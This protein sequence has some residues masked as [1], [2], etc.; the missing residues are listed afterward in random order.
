MF[1]KTT[2]LKG[3]AVAAAALSS[4]GI[5]ANNLYTDYSNVTLYS[6]VAKTYFSFRNMNLDEALLPEEPGHGKVRFPKW[7]KAHY[8]Q[9]GDMS[10]VSEINLR[11]RL[12]DDKDRN[13][14]IS[15]NDYVLISDPNSDAYLTSK[16]WGYYGHD[17]KI[18]HQLESDPQTKTPYKV[19]GLDKECIG[20]WPNAKFKLESTINREK[21]YKT[22]CLK[23]D[24]YYCWEWKYET[25]IA[26]GETLTDGQG[27]TE[28]LFSIIGN[29]NNNQE[30]LDTIQSHANNEAVAILSHRS[31]FMSGDAG[32]YLPTINVANDKWEILGAYP[33]TVL[34]HYCIPDGTMVKLK[35][36]GNKLFLAQDG[37]SFNMQQQGTDFIIENQQYPGG[38]IE[39]TDAFSLKLPNGNYVQISKNHHKM[40]H[41][42]DFHYKSM[43]FAYARNP[44]LDF[45]LNK[46]NLT[47]EVRDS[48]ANHKVPAHDGDLIDPSGSVNEV[49]P[50]DE[51][52]LK[53]HPIGVAMQYSFHSKK[54][55]F[56][57][58]TAFFIKKTG[59]TTEAQ[60][61]GTQGDGM[62]GWG[63]PL[64]NNRPHVLAWESF[65]FD[66][67]GDDDEKCFSSEMHL[68]PDIQDKGTK[69]AF[70][71]SWNNRTNQGNSIRLW[72]PDD[73]QLGSL[74]TT[75]TYLR[76]VNV[77]DELPVWQG[78][79][80]VPVPT[81][82]RFYFSDAEEEQ[83]YKTELAVTSLQA[84]DGR[85]VLA[86]NEGGDNVG[87]FG[88]I[89]QTW[90][91]LTFESAN[92]LKGNCFR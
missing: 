35:N 4:V 65:R 49:F 92:R 15:S 29:T 57:D 53:A 50:V 62:E 48:L 76:S 20:A 39:P 10:D 64:H 87:A 70:K 14:C 6:P 55:S 61:L 40:T 34:R 43:T 21:R 51:Y 30:P 32:S 69:L 86:V 84:H 12:V 81:Q 83:N 27:N 60:F 37:W 17:H 68:H 74:G 26:S 8:S 9:L 31:T 2:M 25:K 91:S 52:K 46:A 73:D 47:L 7:I 38:C 54:N 28:F 89:Q 3:L 58:D 78:L 88:Q 72:N 67:R 82:M 56:C 45:Q 18:L 36:H 5:W 42:Q 75:N 24:Q 22:D 19:V 33:G 66:Y 13:G 90:E 85:Y 71:A 59:A 77:I 41:A 11:F 1:N 16:L 23:A 63:S 79:F 80:T 44:D